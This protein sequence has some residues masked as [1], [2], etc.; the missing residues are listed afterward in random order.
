MNS[1]VVRSKIFFVDKK[2][3]LRDAEVLQSL[4]GCHQMGFFSV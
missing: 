1:N 3:F 2:V 4:D